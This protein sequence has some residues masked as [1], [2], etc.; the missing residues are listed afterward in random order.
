MSA[1][2]KLT[3]GEPEETAGRVDV[4]DVEKR[5]AAQRFDHLIDELGVPCDW[6]SRTGHYK[7]TKAQEK[8]QLIREASSMIIAKA[9]LFDKFREQRLRKRIVSASHARDAIAR[10]Q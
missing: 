3:A 6:A 1:G 7:G 5:L 9:R 8:A 4:F 10:R 2:A